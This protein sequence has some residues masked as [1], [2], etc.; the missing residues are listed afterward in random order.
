M[1]IH[2]S[3]IIRPLVRWLALII[4]KFSGWK[5]SGEKPDLEKYVII[6]AP[7]T[8][9]WDFLFTLCVAFIYRIHPLIMMKDT[10]FFWPLGGI[11]RWLGAL[12]IDRTQSNNIVAQSI[13]AF[14]QRQKLILVVPPS[15]TRNR[16]TRWK[17]GFY[18]IASGANVPI[19]L[20]F[21]DYRR[22]VGGFGPVIQ[23]TGD[24][25]RD[26]IEIRRFYGDISGK[27]PGMQIHPPVFAAEIGE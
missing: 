26:M 1:T 6:A 2:Q 25:V 12:P 18:H 4:F 7:H 15:G 21:L 20:G 27:Y 14:H 24:I 5:T 22:K 8:S 9:N 16:V 23:P 13:A 19:A 11:F 10:W 3:S 17:T